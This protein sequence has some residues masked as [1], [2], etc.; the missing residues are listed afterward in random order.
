MTHPGKGHPHRLGHSNATLGL[1]AV[2]IVVV[3]PLAIVLV[4][5]RARLS[6]AARAFVGWF[7][8]RGLSSLLL[9]LLAD[10]ARPVV[11]YCTCAHEATSAR[12]ARQLRQLGFDAAALTGG[13]DAW[14]ATQPIE[15]KSA[16]IAR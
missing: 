12:V 8:P 16:S 14:Q 1:A 10:R 5:S 6:N 9:I 7:G 15:P 2:T 13:Y 3:R 4:F 11:A